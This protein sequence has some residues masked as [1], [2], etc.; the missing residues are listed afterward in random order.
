MLYE[1]H[2]Y[3]THDGEP[4]EL[5][6]FNGTYVNYLYTSSHS[7]YVHGEDVY[8]PITMKRGSIRVS[9]QEDSNVTVEID[10]PITSKLAQDYAFQT[11]PPDLDL[12]IYRVHRESSDLITYTS[13]VISGVTVSGNV[14][15]FSAPSLLSYALSADIPNVYYQTPCN[16]VLYDWK[17]KVPRADYTVPTIV[18]TTKG[19]KLLVSDVG[20]KPDDFFK[21]GELLLATGE[22]R[23]IVSQI[24]TLIE[25]NYPFSIVRTNAVAE[26]VAGCNLGYD[27]DCENK[28]NNQRNFGGFPFIPAINPFTDGI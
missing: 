6:F 17:C 11:T 4:L 10:V 15:T 14:A 12:T 24:G 19:R 9:T 26:L 3:S 20:G 28:F 7:P 22:R 1:E 8:E 5:Y 13:G 2:E 25:I 16:H 23:A 21:A 27:S 18:S